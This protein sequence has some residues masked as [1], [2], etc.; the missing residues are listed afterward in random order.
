MRLALFQ[1]GQETDTFNPSPTTM[2]DFASFGLY[3]GQEV[4]DRQVGNGTVGG[5]LLAVEQSGRDIEIVPALAWLGGRQRPPHHRGACTTSRI[6]CGA[7]SRPRAPSTA[8][9]CTS[10]ERAPPRA[11]TT[12]RAPC[13]PSPGRRVGDGVPIVT[14]LDHHANVTQAMIDHSDAIVGYRTQPHDPLE[15]GIASTELL[16]RIVA[17]EVHADHRVAQAPAHLAPGAVPDVGRAHEDLVRPGPRP[18]S[19]S[20]AS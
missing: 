15:T 14:T 4:L 17:G 18:R 6:A 10:T 1:M 9:R 16:I 8:W 12:S 19:V 3:E 11:S 2:H 7:T 20:R 13:S 5:F